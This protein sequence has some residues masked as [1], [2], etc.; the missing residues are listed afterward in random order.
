MEDSGKLAHH[1]QFRRTSSS[2]MTGSSHGEERV[3]GHAQRP[4]SESLVVQWVTNLSASKQ[5]L[6]DFK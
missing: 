4:N 1:F 3:K 2:V 5:K 6:H